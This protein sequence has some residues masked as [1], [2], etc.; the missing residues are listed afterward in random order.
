MATPEGQGILKRAGDGPVPLSFAQQRLWFLDQLAPGNPFYNIHTTVHLVAPIT[1][2]I[3]ERALNEIVARHETLRTLFREQNGQ[4]VQVVL[5]HVQ[6]ALATHDLSALPPGVAQDEAVRLA[7]EDARHSFD[8]RHGP[9]LRASLLRMGPADHVVVLT[10]HHIIS[11]GWSLN[12][13]FRELNELYPA[14]LLGRRPSLPALPIQYADFALWQRQRLQG[15]QL[16]RQL[17]YWR[18]Q[19]GGMTPLE[20]PTDHPRPAIQ[21]F[22]GA[23]QPVELPRSLTEALKTLSHSE[24]ATLFMTLLA[25]FKTLLFRYTGQRD[26]V[27]GAPVAGRER[28]ETSNLIGF[29]V[30][31]LVLRT[32]LGQNP[33][34]RQLLRQVRDVAVGAYAHQELPFE[35][36]VEELQPARDLS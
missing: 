9:L 24:G 15:E 8:L 10:M 35:M 36:L 14:L 6:V 1:P 3:L 4:A 12:V 23:H 30:N 26:I 34:F 19:L 22:R 5:P 20:L 32:D 27:I 29:F 33:S 25:A 11:D 21:T 16:E 18:K 2:A 17:A 28:A 31:S 13:F 7:T